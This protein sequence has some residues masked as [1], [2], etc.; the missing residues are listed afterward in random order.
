MARAHLRM[1]A[2]IIRCNRPRSSTR[3]TAWWIGRGSKSAEPRAVSGH[4]QPDDAPILV[5]H[6]RAK[7]AARRG[8]GV[9]NVTFQDAIGPRRS[10][11]TKVRIHEALE[12]PSWSIR[13]RPGVVEL[14]LRRT[15]RRETAESLGTSAS[16]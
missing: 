16:T 11:R 10:R 5:D 3:R 4:C 14:L 9:K 12:A 6:A 13:R 2:P 1:S 15:H 8:G 7:H